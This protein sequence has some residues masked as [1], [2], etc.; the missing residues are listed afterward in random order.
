MINSESVLREAL[1]L[2]WRET[3]ARASQ[4]GRINQG[5]PLGTYW[6]SILRQSAQKIEIIKELLKDLPC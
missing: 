5:D 3:E 1:E 2:L 6:N 4:L